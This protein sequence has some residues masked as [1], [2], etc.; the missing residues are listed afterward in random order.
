MHK[1]AGLLFTVMFVMAA[2]VGPTLPYSDL[3]HAAAIEPA[4]AG[5][6]EFT[7]RIENISGDSTLPAPLSPGAWAVHD[8]TVSFFEVGEPAL[9]GLAEIAEDGSPGT[10]ATTLGGLGGISS[11]GVFNTPVGAAGPGPI[12][13]GQAYE[14]TFNAAP[15]E[16]LSLASMYIQSNDVFFGPFPE[17]VELFDDEGNPLPAR[18][19][20]TDLPFWDAGSEVNE[21][22]GMGPNQAPRQ[23]GP[24][25]GPEEGV[26]SLFSNTTRA[27]PLASG[28]VDVTVM[29]S[30]GTYTMTVE[31]I[32]DN[33][34]AI[35]TP[36]SP[37]F[38]ATHDDTWSLF[39]NGQP[40]LGNGLEALAEDG[41]A[42]TLGALP[43]NSGGR[44]EVGVQA[45]H[46]SGTGPANTGDSYQFSVTPTATYP[47]LTIAT[48]VVE[49][50]DVFLAFEPMGV[51]LLNELGQ[52]RSAEAVNADI[53]R[54]LDVW[55]AGTEA[56]EVPGAG[57]NQPVRQAGADT[58]PADPDDTVRIYSDA[59][60]DLA[61][62]QGTPG[63]LGD[64]LTIEVTLNSGTTFDVT[65]T[66]TSGNSE[67]EGILTP[68]AW[69]THDDTVSLFETGS[70][71]SSGLEQLAED[72]DPSGLV[73]ELTSLIGSGVGTAGSEG[74]GPFTSGNSESFQVTPTM[75]YPYLSVASMVVPSNDTFMAFFPQGLR[76]LD[77]SGNPRSD[78]DIA[79]DIETLMVAWDAG[80][81][82]NQAGAAGPD[83]AG[84]GL[85]EGANTGAD[86]SNGAPGVRLL[87]VPGGS[88]G[89]DPVWHYPPLTDV[90]R[91]TLIPTVESDGPGAVFTSTNDSEGNGVVMYDRGN[92]GRLTYIGEYATGGDG[93]G[94]G[95]T[96]PVDPLGSQSSLIVHEEYLYVVNAGSNEVSALSI[97][98][99]GL[100][101]IGTYDSGGSYPVS[102][103]A[104]DDWLYVLNAGGNSNI[105]GYS[106]E[107]DGSL[108]PLSNSSRTFGASN[109]QLPNTLQSPSQV[110]FSPMGDMLVVSEK[111]S[112][113]IH[114]FTVGTDG[115][116]AASP[117]S[118]A[119]AGTLPFSFTFDSSGTLLVTEVIGQG[120]GGAGPPTN[121]SVSTYTVNAD[122]TLNVISTSVRNFQTATCWI[123]GIDEYYFVSNTASDTISSYTLA[124]DGSLTL[125]EEESFSTASGAAPTDLAVS[126]NFIYVLN[127]GLDRVTSYEADPNDGSVASLS[128]AAN[129]LGDVTPGAV[130]LATYEFETEIYLPFISR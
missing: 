85:Q 82:R 5:A 130:G 38:Y 34:G 62:N 92:D 105:Y 58:G 93:S 63:T 80:T 91:V 21:A 61:D 103:T 29:E 88:D 15:G 26:V 54:E 56:N 31:N 50:N 124:S 90:L 3:Q 46:T 117:V 24:D 13:D 97:S 39:E 68:V 11:S 99:D 102:L 71:A 10:L 70:P 87:N 2:L 125:L 35:K 1:T 72:G 57:T 12:Q 120:E 66:N 47:Y 75:A 19:I 84:P 109:S 30:G 128:N 106:I 121:G 14:F 60:N 41:D 8:D 89:P 98:R 115:L 123:V 95:L 33:A 22:P 7:V 77:E 44:G 18:D 100:S 49:S 73:S 104:Y 118:N 36:I 51:P 17:G 114:V 16:V 6:T 116:P 52:P 27:L 40:V 67:F 81:E 69:T 20:T 32:S 122:G 48:M 78:T 64:F 83:Q 65:V 53:D 119:S 110:E 101:L 37:V 126:G 129:I 43:V 45:D 108:T 112:N 59:T 23:S 25:T 94:P 76:L 4:Q 42:T 28:I 55:D 113:E 111:A 86:E 79:A 96:A 74:T 127:S 107:D 9:P